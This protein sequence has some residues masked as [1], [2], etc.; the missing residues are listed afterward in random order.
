MLKTLLDAG[1]GART[2]NT[3]LPDELRLVT[4]SPGHADAVVRWRNDPATRLLFL[5]N[6][7]LTSEKQ[8]L[9]MQQ[10]SELPGDHTFIAL[11][12]GTQVG[13]VAIHEI[14]F[15]APT[16]EYGRILIDP[17]WRRRGLG[18]ALTGWVLAHGSLTCGLKSTRTAYPTIGLS[19]CCSKV[20]ASAIGL[21]IH[22]PSDRE[23][24]RLEIK[25]AEWRGLALEH[26]HRPLEPYD[27]GP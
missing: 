7:E 9:W 22:S 24:T 6:Q 10:R 27:L 20:S 3:G 14:D 11:W 15:E 26:F 5:S 23:V 25:L 17:G 4:P 13:M 8:L 18:R 21:S 1:T 16:G 2:N 12:Q 19:I